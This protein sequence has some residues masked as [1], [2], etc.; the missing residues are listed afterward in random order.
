MRTTRLLA[1]GLVILTVGSF[2]DLFRHEFINYDDPAYVTAND[3]VKGGLTSGGVH[4]AFTTYTAANWH[5]LTW[6]SMMLD[7]ELFGADSA[8]GFLFTN[9]LFHVGSVLLLFG[10]LRS[11][12]GRVW[13]SAFVTAVFAIHPLRVESVAWVSERKDVLSI[14]FGMLT[15]RLYVSFVQRRRPLPYLLMTLSYLVGMFAKQT[16]VTLPFVLLL[17]DYWP[18]GR[19]SREVDSGVGGAQASSVRGL[20]WRRMFA[21]TIEKL[22]LFVISGVFCVVAAHAQ[23]EGDAVADLLAVPMLM[24]VYN[25]IYSYVAYLGMMFWPVNLSLIYPHPEYRIPTSWLVGSGMFL[26]GMTIL[27]V[28]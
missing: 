25:A 20:P 1:I 14:F 24:R 16:L 22:P 21:L 26:V 15:L 3:F 4:W 18:F 8:R 13:C 11:A 7:A 6:L 19:L 23:K 17:M 28:A 10:S 27:V 12:T 2:A 5:P 9:L